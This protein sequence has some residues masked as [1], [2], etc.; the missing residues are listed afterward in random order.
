MLRAEHP[1]ILRVKFQLPIFTDKAFHYMTPAYLS[2]QSYTSSIPFLVFLR[3]TS[4]FCSSEELSNFLPPNTLF[5]WPESPIP[6]QSLIFTQL[7][8]LFYS[9]FGSQLEHHFFREASLTLPLPF[10]LSLLN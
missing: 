9:H 2:I 8:L 5:A 7:T 4:L 1:T 6:T 10:P 3:H